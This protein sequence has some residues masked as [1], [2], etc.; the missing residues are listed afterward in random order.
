MN[1]YTYAKMNPK[2]VKKGSES[3]PYRIWDKCYSHNDLQ[4]KAKLAEKCPLGFN[5]ASIYMLIPCMGVS[6][7]VLSS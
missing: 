2:K 1:P 4:Q 3:E 6:S 7:P 5:Y